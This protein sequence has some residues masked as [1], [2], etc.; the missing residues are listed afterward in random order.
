MVKYQDLKERLGRGEVIVLD[1]AVGT[2]LQTMGVPMDPYC[3]AAI[4]NYSHPYTVRK[5]HEDYIKAGVDVI[6]TNTYSSAHHNYEPVGLSE[7]VFELNLRAVVLADGNRIGAEDLGL[8]EQAESLSLN[9]REAREQAERQVI[10]RALVVHNQNISHAAEALCISR[11]S[12]Y[13][14]MKKLGMTEPAK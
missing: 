12:L 6:T 9:L 13:N 2:Q 8:L 4:A 7:Q 1:G 3:W 11:P 5:M 14:L 10:Q